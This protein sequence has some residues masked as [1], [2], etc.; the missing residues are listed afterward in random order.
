M[1][2]IGRR[3]SSAGVGKEDTFLFLS[4]MPRGDSGLSQRDGEME[5]FCGREREVVADFFSRYW[6]QKNSKKIS[7]NVISFIFLSAW[8]VFGAKSKSKRRDYCINST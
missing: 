5:I 4:W 1:E 7:L 6:Q 8:S 3:Y 2:V